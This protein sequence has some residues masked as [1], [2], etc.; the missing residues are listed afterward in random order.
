MASRVMVRWMDI[1]YGALSAGEHVRRRA[2]EDGLH[3]ED[4]AL[5]TGA[6]VAAKGRGVW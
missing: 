6:V 2:V 3:G 4:G 1:T 5:A